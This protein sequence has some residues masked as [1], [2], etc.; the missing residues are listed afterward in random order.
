M[1]EVA[2]HRGE[3]G[4]T[5]IAGEDLVVGDVVNLYTGMRIP[6]DCVLLS[7]TDFTVD[8][9]GQTGEPDHIEKVPLSEENY[10]A[11]PNPFLLAKSLIQSGQGTALVCAVGVST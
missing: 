11:N 6:A 2:V 8:E 5:T 10:Q 1:E 3:S 7:G 4:V 9:S